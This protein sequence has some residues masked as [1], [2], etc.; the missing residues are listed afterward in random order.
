MADSVVRLSDLTSSLKVPTHTMC[1][2]YQARHSGVLNEQAQKLP[3]FTSYVQHHDSGK[4]RHSVISTKPP[5]YNRGPIIHM[6]YM[7]TTVQTSSAHCTY[8]C[9]PLSVYTST[10]EQPVSYTADPAGA[11]AGQG[12]KRASGA[13]KHY[14]REDAAREPHP[15]LCTQQ[16]LADVS[17]ASVAV[18]LV[19]LAAKDHRASQ[20]ATG[21][22]AVVLWSA[23]ARAGETLTYVGIVGGAA[24]GLDA[25]LSPGGGASSAG[26]LMVEL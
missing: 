26:L 14:G 11:Q 6:P 2:C 15:P 3:P 21:H 8:I 4:N 9:I 25:A 18:D 13:L 22:G 5:Q 12:V 10:H 7:S 17:A 19:L 23:G 24:A 20:N 1:Y 16:S